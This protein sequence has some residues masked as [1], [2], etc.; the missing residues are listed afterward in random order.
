MT[1]LFQLSDEV[2]RAESGD[3]FVFPTTDILSEVSLLI[4]YLY[5]LQTLSVFGLETSTCHPP[6]LSQF[7]LIVE[8]LQ[9]FLLILKGNYLILLF[10]LP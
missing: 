4:H 5:V 2:Y 10:M 8:V 9:P 7:V 6:S 1:V 3:A